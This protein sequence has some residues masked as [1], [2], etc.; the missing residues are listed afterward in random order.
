VCALVVA[1]I[2]SV[3]AGSSILAFLSIFAILVVRKIKVRRVRLSAKTPIG[4][5]T[6]EIDG[7]TER[8]ELPPGPEAD[9][10]PPSEHDE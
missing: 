9:Q 10:P 3:S 2:I 4:F 5:F 8:D 6:V 7:Q 1:D